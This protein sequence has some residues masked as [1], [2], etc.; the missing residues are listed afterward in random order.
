MSLEI[1][2]DQQLRQALNDLPLETQRKLGA[3]FVASV[4]H[5]STHPVISQGIQVA[6][7][8]ERSSAELEFA[9]K[10][11]KKLAIDSYTACGHDADWS[12]QA[13]HF[14]ATAITA[15]LLPDE[16]YSENENIAW[17]AAMQARMAKNCEMILQD[18]GEIDNEAARQYTIT[19]ELLKAGG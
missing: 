15:C 13:E 3:H 6:K 16:Q 14:V 19:M 7:D 17:K 11:A 2:N 18:K 12:A 4:S 9:Y 10:S 5:L 8:P 1:T